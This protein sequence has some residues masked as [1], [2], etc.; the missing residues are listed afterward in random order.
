MLIEHGLFFRCRNRK[1]VR[2][3]VGFRRIDSGFGRLGDNR[4]LCGVQVVSLYGGIYNI[5]DRPWNGIGR[6]KYKRSV[7]RRDHKDTFP[8]LWRP[9]RG[10]VNDLRREPVSATR[11]G[12]LNCFIGRAAVVRLEIFHVFQN[13][14]GRILRIEDTKNLVK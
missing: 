14:H 1:D 13:T 5:G 3:S 4:I 10:C 11:K 12:G 9:A 8:S 2:N 6:G 7:L